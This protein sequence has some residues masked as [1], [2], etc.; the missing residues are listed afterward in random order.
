[1]LLENPT[2]EYL[3]FDLKNHRYTEPVINYVKESF[4]NTKINII[5]G[6]SVET[7]TQY[8]LDN[9]EEMGTYDLCH[10]D[11]GHIERVFS[12]DYENTKKLLNKDGYV[13]FDD[14]DQH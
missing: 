2:A 8:V 9:P 13:V 14:Y 3:L 7:M 5:F 10:L 11:G 6:D 4:P 12:V 1:M